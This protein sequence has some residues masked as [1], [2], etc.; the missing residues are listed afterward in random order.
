MLQ[1]RS[2][3]SEV[4]CA[5]PLAWRIARVDPE[6]DLTLAH[7]ERIVSEAAVLWESGTGR[8]L[9]GHD[10]EGGFP[11]RFVYD[12][13]QEGLVARDLRM[14]A[15]DDL[16]ARVTEARDA[17]VARSARYEAAASAHMERMADLEE[18][19]SE[20]NATVEQWNEAGSISDSLRIA[21]A[22]V[23]EALQREQRELA[24]ERRGLEAEQQ[25]V[26]EAAARVNDLVLEHQ[27]LTEQFVVDFPSSAVEAGEYR[28]AVRR[29][30]G[31]VESVSR[32]IR[33][34]RFANDAD[35]RILAAHE[36]GHAL[37]LGHTLD[38]RGVMHES[39]R[40]DDP[41]AGLASTDVGLFNSICPAG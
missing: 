9:F 11:I 21:L 6:F 3:G 4:P 23:G 33:L 2:L 13:R 29:V 26:N 14:G 22:S 28:E 19:V 1:E 39:A 20:H 25:A 40:L 36:L 31:R 10:P 32:E 15:I 38:P 41:V 17:Q 18:R 8:A 27:R 16:A 12:D 24:T 5:V 35:L 37:G 7:A 34:Y 30:D